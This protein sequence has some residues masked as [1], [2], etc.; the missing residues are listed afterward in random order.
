M[1]NTARL[2]N[3]MDRSG[4]LAARFGLAL[5]FVASGL[6]KLADPVSTGA[7]IESRGLGMGTAFALAAGGLELL[8]GASVLLGFRARW[9]ALALAGFL[10]PATLM[11]HNP[12]GL[13]AAA[14]QFE[15]IQIMKNVAIG[16]GLLAIAAYGSG[17]LS[18]D[19]WLART[20]L[21]VQRVAQRG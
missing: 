18:L 20:Q 2:N 8:A 3:F 10:V 6:A 4:P 9:G 11:F 13:D 17:P 19:Q 7:L 15:M 21:G 12:I 16:G 1:S 5:I 14:L